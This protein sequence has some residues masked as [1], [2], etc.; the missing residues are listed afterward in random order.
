MNTA[1]KGII[2]LESLKDPKILDTFTVLNKE[3]DEDWHLITVEANEKQIESLSQEL[4]VG[5]WYTHFWKGDDVIVVF[6]NK[7]MKMKHS[8]KSTWQPVIEY[9]QSIGIPTEQLDFPIE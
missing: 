9:G 4:K 7:I 1:Y 6:P 8:D 2:V 5:T 3:I